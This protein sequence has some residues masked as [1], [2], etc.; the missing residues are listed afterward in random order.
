VLAPNGRIFFWQ[1]LYEPETLPR[2]KTFER[3]MAEGP[4]VGIP[5]IAAEAVLTAWRML[6]RKRQ[7]ATGADIDGVHFRYYTREKL[8]QSLDRW[9]L[10]VTRELSP[11]ACPYVFVEARH[12]AS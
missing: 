6:K 1:G 4:I 10:R 8:R 2:Q 7:L 3:S 9:G 11:R 5:L 12:G